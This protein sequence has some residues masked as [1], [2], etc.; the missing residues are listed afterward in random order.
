M[1]LVGSGKGLAPS[2]VIG[3]E[4]LSC[5]RGQSAPLRLDAFRVFVH[6]TF[7]Q[8]IVSVQV[9]FTTQTCYNAVNWIQLGEGQVSHHLPS[10]FTS[11]S[12][13]EL[14]STSS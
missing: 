9:A 10:R 2:S 11:Y 3:V 12:S 5:L 8:H 7:I 1:V 4:F 13:S 6:S 14:S